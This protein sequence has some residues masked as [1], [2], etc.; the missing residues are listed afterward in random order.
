MPQKS[1][2][3]WNQRTFLSRCSSLGYLYLEELTV[4]CHSISLGRPFVIEVRECDL[5]NVSRLTI[6]KSDLLRSIDI[7]GSSMSSDLIESICGQIV[8]CKELDRLELRG[9]TV[10]GHPLNNVE[11][12]PYLDLPA[13]REIN[14]GHNTFQPYLMQY[15]LSQLIAGNQLKL[16][17]IYLT[18]STLTGCLSSFLPDHHP[19]LVSLSTLFLGGTALQEDDLK[20]LSNIVQNNQLPNLQYLTISDNTLTGNFSNFLPESSP[21]LP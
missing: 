4:E 3:I 5:S 16:Y 8:R 10:S 18:D 15:L 7:T 9:N 6:Q 21:G 19:G 1:V 12:P 11:D 20:H 2:N 17:L 14:L 13:L